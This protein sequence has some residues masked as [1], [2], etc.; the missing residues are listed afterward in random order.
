MMNIKKKIM[1]IF[2]TGIMAFSASPFVLS[3]IHI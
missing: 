2:A 1:V 3:L